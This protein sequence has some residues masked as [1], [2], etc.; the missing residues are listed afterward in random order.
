MEILLPLSITLAIETGIYMILHHK[1]LKLFVVVSLM[2]MLLNVSMNIGLYFV[3]DVTLYWIILAVSEIATIFIESFIVYVFMR[4][5]YIKILLFAFIANAASF[6]VGLGL[7]FLYQTKIA[8]Y[9]VFGLF[10]LVY[11]ISY[12]FTLSASILNYRNRNDN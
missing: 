6:F 2:N 4:F 3:N 8:L 7:S 12:L 5:K 9:V 10:M 1:D 11:L